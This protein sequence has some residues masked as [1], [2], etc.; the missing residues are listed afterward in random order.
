[1]LMIFCVLCYGVYSLYVVSLKHGKTAIRTSALF[2]VTKFSL[3]LRTLSIVQNCNKL[4]NTA[5]WKLDVSIFR[6]GEGRE[7]PIL[8]DPLQRANRN[9]CMC[10]TV[11]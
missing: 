2:Y 1:M 6:S 3:C 9:H 7:T 8:L 10:F 4:E 5:F 11:C